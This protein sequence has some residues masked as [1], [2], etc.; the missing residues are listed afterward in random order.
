[1]D[2]VEPITTGNALLVSEWDHEIFLDAV[3]MYNNHN[4]S[5]IVVSLVKKNA[6]T[7]EMFFTVIGISMLSDILEIG[8][9]MQILKMNQTKRS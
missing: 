8:K 5:K 3:S 7:G 4:G 6:E 9:R 1:M 2:K